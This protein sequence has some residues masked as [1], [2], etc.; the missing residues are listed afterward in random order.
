MRIAQMAEQ[1][2]EVM[3]RSSTAGLP[4]SRPEVRTSHSDHTQVGMM[5]EIKYIIS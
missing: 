1:S 2:G 4:P 5:T 3:V